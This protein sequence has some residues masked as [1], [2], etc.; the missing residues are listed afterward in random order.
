MDKRLDQRL[1]WLA[2]IIDGEG[3]IHVRARQLNGA[4]R[5]GK[6]YGPISTIGVEIQ[7]TDAAM[8]Q[9]VIDIADALCIQTRVYWYQRPDRPTAKILGRVLFSGF[10]PARIILE[11]VLPYLVTKK[12]RAQLALQAIAARARA[13]GKGGWKPIQD[14]PEFMEI[15]RLMRDLNKQGVSQI[16][17]NNG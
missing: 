1:A 15:T 14:D 7:N 13:K 10:G 16:G 5:G 9:E 6:Y 17:E 3:C 12:N 2:G 11:A 4:V 8:L